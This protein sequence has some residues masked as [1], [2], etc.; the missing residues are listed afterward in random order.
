MRDQSHQ[1]SQIQSQT[2]TT[3]GLRSFDYIRKKRLS[4]PESLCRGYAMRYRQEGGRVMCLVS[5]VLHRY[6]DP[7]WRNLHMLTEVPSP[8]GSLED[9]IQL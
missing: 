8:P 1:Q 5:C 2:P 7:V 9:D 3:I 4:H 6:H